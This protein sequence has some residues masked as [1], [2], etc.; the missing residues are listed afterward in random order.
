MGRPPAKIGTLSA[1]TFEKAS[2]GNWRAR[3]RVCLA[4]GQVRQIMAV[5]PTKSAAVD[6]LR[7]KAND[8]TSP[9]R[10]RPGAHRGLFRPRTPRRLA[11][12]K[13]P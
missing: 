4:N 13:T 7:R 5:R 6:A 1:P 11:R 9:P 3:S 12:A 10:P 2:S 8:L